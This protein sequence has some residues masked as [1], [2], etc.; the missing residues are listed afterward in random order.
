MRGRNK[1]LIIEAKP[2]E[3]SHGY[4]LASMVSQ[5]IASKAIRT[6]QVDVQLKVP[7]E[8]L[9]P[10]VQ[11]W[12]SNQSSLSLRGWMAHIAQGD[13]AKTPPEW[14]QL[15]LK[16]KSVPKAGAKPPPSPGSAGGPAKALTRLSVTASLLAG[17]SK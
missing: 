5:F 2:G 1:I 4:F 14:A 7:Y 16:P 10:R 11:S 17:D 6:N 13:A 9:V 3:P 8:C 15:W 12:L